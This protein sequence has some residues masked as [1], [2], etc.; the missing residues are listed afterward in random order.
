MADPDDGTN[1]SFTL[2]GQTYSIS[3][4]GTHTVSLTANQTCTVAETVAANWALSSASCVDYRTSL[5]VGSFDNVIT[6]QLTNNRP[7]A[8]RGIDVTD[9]VP[10]GLSDVISSISGSAI[11][12]IAVRFG[13]GL[14]WTVISLASGSN[15]S[16]IFQGVSVCIAP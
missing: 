1:F 13:S 14:N 3:G 8:A 2:D 16:L 7:V 15:T 9:I 4:S 5:Q 12:T 11:I 10:T 6:L